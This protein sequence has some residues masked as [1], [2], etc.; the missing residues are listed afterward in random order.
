MGILG[1][2]VAL[3]TLRCAGAFFVPGAAMLDLFTWEML[4]TVAGAALATIIVTNTIAFATGY[5]AKWVAL[6]IAFL[7]SIAAWVFTSERT[8]SGFV[9]AV[10]NAFVI[11]A[12]AIGANQIVS[13]L[14]APVGVQSKTPQARRFFSSWW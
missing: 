7:L 12:S 5:S 2:P 14:D 6:V 9:L 8:P 1:G 10:L 4:A 11:Y 13:S 3:A